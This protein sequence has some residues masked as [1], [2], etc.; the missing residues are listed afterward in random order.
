MV[1]NGLELC[2]SNKKW[3]DFC[4]ESRN[5]TPFCQTWFIESVSKNSI[6][7]FWYED[8]EIAASILLQMKDGIPFQPPFSIHQSICFSSS[9]DKLPNEE[10]TRI[11]YKLLDSIIIDITKK[12]K[13]L[14]LSLHPD[15]IDIRPLQW[16]N[17]HNSELGKFR[18]NLRYTAIRSLLNFKNIDVLLEEIRKDRKADYKKFLKS[19]IKIENKVDIDTF[20]DLYKMTFERQNHDV[21]DQSLDCIRLILEKI[22]PKLGFMLTAKLADDTPISSTVILLGNHQAHSLFT[23][24]NPEYRKLGANSALVVEAMMICE[25]LG[26]DEFDFVG[27]NSPNRADF[28]ISFNCELRSYFEANLE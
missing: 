27:A 11:H 17:Y 10:R 26:I 3:D 24:N 18:I 15:I 7:Y 1:K 16:H 22:T 21:D 13:R 25:N 19:N 2:E 20:L 4:F 28:K 9:I 12:Y 23:A 6:K 5:G 8:G 14:S